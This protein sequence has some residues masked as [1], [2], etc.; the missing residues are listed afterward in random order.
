MSSPLVLMAAD[1]NYPTD[2]WN[3]YLTHGIVSWIF[4]L[5][6]FILMAI[7]SSDL[8]LFSS[9][10]T[11]L[12]WIWPAITFAAM[13]PVG[14][15][16]IMSGPHRDSKKLNGWF[17]GLIVASNIYTW[18]LTFINVIWLF[19]MWLWTAVVHTFVAGEEKPKSGYAWIGILIATTLQI[20]YTW[21]S[22]K[23]MKM[24]RCWWKGGL[25]EGGEFCE[26]FNDM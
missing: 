11:L 20:V 1:D 18:F 17:Y 21:S 4:G 23:S 24:V 14:V 26:R 9:V 6:M 2:Y 13:I 25:E 15:L 10:V 8:G 16:F 22:K 5:W 12:S 7:W 3:A 19:Y